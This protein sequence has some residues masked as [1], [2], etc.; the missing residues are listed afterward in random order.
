[1]RGR[2]R[3]VDHDGPD[4]PV[5]SGQRGPKHGLCPALDTVGDGNTFAVAGRER[6]WDHATLSVELL[7]RPR[8]YATL[9]DG[10]P[11]ED[12]ARAQEVAVVEHQ[13]VHRSGSSPAVSVGTGPATTVAAAFTAGWAAGVGRAICPRAGGVTVLWPAQLLTGPPKAAVRRE[14]RGGGRS[15]CTRRTST[16]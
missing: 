16:G 14:T 11:A 1:M 4:T 7:H 9:G 12:E 2:I 3:H 5:A 10:A 6:P 13:P 15:S 8:C